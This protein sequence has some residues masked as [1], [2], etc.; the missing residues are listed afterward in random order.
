MILINVDR[1]FLDQVKSMPLSVS[2]S[3]ALTELQSGDQAQ[4]SLAPGDFTVPGIGI[5]TL[6]HTDESSSNSGFFSSIGVQCRSAMRQP[7]LA[8]VQTYWSKERVCSD[9][10]THSPAS[11]DL[12]ADTWLGSTGSAPADFSLAPIS[13]SFMN[14]SP[15]LRTRPIPEPLPQRVVASLPRSPPHH[16]PLPP[17]RPNPD[18]DH[19]PQPPNPPTRQK[20][21]RSGSRGI[22]RLTTNNQQPTT[23]LSTHFS[24]SNH[25]ESTPTA[26]LLRLAPSPLRAYPQIRTY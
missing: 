14:F 7:P 10:K 6:P 18:P 23:T 19:H 16:N 5:C 25:P 22:Q 2:I 21:S 13:V 26:P 8:Y 11:A 3:L 20:R 24:T 1:A 15:L 4:I 17:P 9:S 12:F